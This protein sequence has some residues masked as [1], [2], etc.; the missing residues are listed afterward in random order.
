MKSWYIA[1]RPQTVGELDQEIIRSQIESFIKRG[2]FPSALLFAGPK[3]TGKTS[4]ARII[5]KILNCDAYDKKKELGEPCNKCLTCLEITSGVSLSVIELDAA[6]HR[7]IDDIRAIRDTVKLSA[8]G[9]TKVYIIDE[10]HMLTSEAANALLK[11]LEEP[12]EYVV[13]ILAT[14]EIGKI[15]ETIRSRATVLQFHKSNADESKRALS[16]VIG[17]EGLEVDKEVID[18][19]V[20]QAGGSFRDAIKLLEQISHKKKVTVQMLKETFKDSHV[21]PDE[22]LEAVYAKNAQA[23]LSQIKALVDNG[24]NIRQFA[25]SVL[26]ELHSAVLN[27][28]GALQAE[29]KNESLNLEDMKRLIGLFLQALDQMR[30][31]PIPELPLEL[32]VVEWCSEGKWEVRNGRLDIDVRSEK[33]SH[34]QRQSPASSGVIPASHIA[35]RTPSDSDPEVGKSSPVSNDLWYQFISHVKPH[36]HSVAAL[37]KSARPLSFDGQKL[38]LSVFYK[39]HKDKLEEAVN[40]RIIESV[41]GEVFNANPVRVVFLL[42]DKPQEVVEREKQSVNKST[43]RIDPEEELIKAAEEIF[44]GVENHQH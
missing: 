41:A 12:P 17:R 29:G 44:G 11:T 21:R 8:P 10:A 22:F 6:S 26:D 5:A 43:V 32:V 7:G 23:A 33:K 13:F 25:V 18:F 19:V 2:K 34:P 36:N 39:F 30:T 16:R 4:T 27:S 1:H 40:L 31:S 20:R 38:T 24:V 35:S 3:G 15:P 42:G 28:V 9:R 14:T 37:L